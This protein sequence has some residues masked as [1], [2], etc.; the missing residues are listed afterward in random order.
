MLSQGKDP[1]LAVIYR[2]ISEGIP[3]VSSLKTKLGFL[4]D[5]DKELGIKGHH[6]MLERSNCLLT[7]KHSCFKLLFDMFFI[8]KA[9]K[10]MVPKKYKINVSGGTSRYFSVGTH[11]K[12]VY[13]LYK[14]IP[15]DLYEYFNA[16][17]LAY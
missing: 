14:T 13:S 9:E 7:I 5:N 3:L 2:Q 17:V 4:C 11:R 16:E 12:T 1:Y 8:I 6:G 15:T 10:V